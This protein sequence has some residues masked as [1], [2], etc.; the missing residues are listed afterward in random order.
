[1]S[2][3]LKQRQETW[4]VGAREESDM[5]CSLPL[6]P[7]MLHDGIVLQR[8]GGHDQTLQERIS[9]IYGVDSFLD[10]GEGVSG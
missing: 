7:I 4:R 9:T 8:S 5:D 3:S 1:M 2:V 10:V 6:E